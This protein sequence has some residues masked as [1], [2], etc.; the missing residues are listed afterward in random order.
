MSDLIASFD[1]WQIFIQA[2]VV[3]ALTSLVPSIL[4]WRSAR[5]AAETASRTAKEQTSDKRVDTYY[6]DIRE[7]V[8]KLRDRIQAVEIEA[9]DQRGYIRELEDHVYELR[10][11][12]KRLSPTT[13]LPPV[14]QRRRRQPPA[15]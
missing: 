8:D 12:I 2:I 14:P 5:A 1:Q 11:L 4:A 3:A 6:E 7:E 15:K 10:A 13:E 9:E